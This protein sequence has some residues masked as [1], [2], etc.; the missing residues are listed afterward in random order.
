[1]LHTRVHWYVLP[2]LLMLLCG[3]AFSVYLLTLAAPILRS[4]RTADTMASEC[5]LY[6]ARDQYETALTEAEKANAA[7]FR[8]ETVDENTGTLFTC[9]NRV[10]EKYLGVCADADTEYEA[11]VLGIEKL[12]ESP[13]KKN[14]PF[15]SMLQAKKAYEAVSNRV[16]AV[17]EQ[18]TYES[19]A[20]MPYD[21]IIKALD[22]FGTESDS[23]YIKGYVEYFKA[24]ATQFYDPDDS[25]TILGYMEKLLEYLP[26]EYVNVYSTQAQFYMQNGEYDKVTRAADAILEKN[27]NYTDAYAWKAEVC[28]KSGDE[29]AALAVLEEL[30]RYVPDDPLYYKLQVKYAM[31]RDD[32]DAANEYCNACDT[33]NSETADNVFNAL[34]AKQVDSIPRKAMQTY[35]HYIDYS[36]YEAALMLVE[37]DAD[38]AFNIA[39]NYAFNYAYYY[40]YVYGDGS[41][42]TQGV[43]NMTTLCAQMNR[44][45][46]SAEV[47]DA[48]SGIGLC[49]ETTQQ[50]IDGKYTPREV[51]VEG[52]VEIL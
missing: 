22:D 38:S 19:A 11:A 29:K 10:F 48:V 40:A 30:N 43:I 35:L 27:K 23:P 6:E 25:E 14:P 26:D 1:M 42:L 8:V 15:D 52:K 28:Y 32:P 16:S 12:G 33:A 21:E 41:A 36:L 9:G 3:T 39:Y 46:T 20:D 34:L 51:F 31:L 5:R 49:D 44:N 2:I 4:I 24:S 50:I 37:D 47:L 13:M 7:F 45:E 18:Y 17:N